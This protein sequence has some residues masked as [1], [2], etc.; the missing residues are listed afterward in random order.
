LED[1]LYE[2]IHPDILDT[3]SFMFENLKKGYDRQYAVEQ[4]KKDS[5]FRDSIVQSITKNGYTWADNL[6]Q[7]GQQDS[8]FFMPE[9]KFPLLSGDSIYSD[10]I[11]S[12]FLLID[13]WYISCY[14]CMKA[15]SELSS[16]DTLYSESL[17]RMVSINVFDKDTAKMSK[18]VKNFNLK[19]D[20]ACAYAG[21]EIYDMSRKMGKCQGYPQLYLI[22]MKTK[23]VIWRSCGWYAG[24]TKDIKAIIKANDK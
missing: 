22:D 10:S 21:D 3:I 17:L 5:A 2:Y 4:A 9:W 14:P 11:N 24:F 8:L 6:P 15:M 12:R 23:Q 16:I 13:M 1:R 18:V 7:E 20:V 19:C